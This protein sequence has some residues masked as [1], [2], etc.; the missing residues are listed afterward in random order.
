MTLFY[1]IPGFSQEPFFHMV[2]HWLPCGPQPPV[3]PPAG[4][5]VQAVL[6]LFLQRLKAK[7]IFFIRVCKYSDVLKI[8]LR[9]NLFST[10]IY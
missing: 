10:S 1:N 8:Q 2:L 5:L 6:T 3:F 7:D 9:N 4:I